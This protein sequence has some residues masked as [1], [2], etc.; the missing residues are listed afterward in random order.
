[1]TAFL[2]P[3]TIPA[4]LWGQQGFAAQGLAQTKQGASAYRGALHALPAEDAQGAG[5]GDAPSL[6]WA[7][8]STWLAWSSSRAVTPLD[9]HFFKGAKMSKGG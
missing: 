9:W 7:G 6:V 1:M 3:V 8:V 5:R 4:M 2:L